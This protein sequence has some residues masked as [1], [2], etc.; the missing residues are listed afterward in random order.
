VISDTR[1]TRVEWRRRDYRSL[2]EG[3]SRKGKEEDR[4]DT[5][6]RYPCLVWIGDGHRFHLH[7]SLR[8]SRS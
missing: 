2:G 7:D 3:R 6:P 1:K 5:L 8:L 4:V